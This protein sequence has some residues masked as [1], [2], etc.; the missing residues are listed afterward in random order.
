MSAQRSLPPRLF[1][2]VSAPFIVAVPP[3][4]SHSRNRILLVGQETYGWGSDGEADKERGLLSFWA[5]RDAVIDLAR[6]Y[7]SFDLGRGWSSPL[8]R[9][10]H[11][12]AQRFEA[13]DD[14]AVLWSNLLR[15]DAGPAANPSKS[16]WINFTDDEFEA[17]LDWE[18][19]LFHAEMAAL[20]PRIAIFSTGPRYDGALRKLY[21]DVVHE[22]IGNLPVGQLARLNSQRMNFTAFRVYHPN[23]LAR[24]KGKPAAKALLSSLDDIAL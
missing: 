12:L 17:V 24:P 23:F 7:E 2:R 3:N 6:R 9:F 13:N 19:D 15:V 20:A 4:W 5:G 11:L 10:H 16:A 18:A 22:Q 1:Q 14:R 21:P 8:W